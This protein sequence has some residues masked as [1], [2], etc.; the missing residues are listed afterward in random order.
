MTHF[1]DSSKVVNGGSVK[2]TDSGAT[3]LLSGPTEESVRIEILAREQHGSR[4]V[5]APG[6]VGARWF[7]TITKP[8]T[9]RPPEGVSETEG[10]APRCKIER[11]GLQVVVRG[12]TEEAVHEAIEN[13]LIGGAK[14]LAPPE[15]ARGEW[16]AVL[17][18]PR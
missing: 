11:L 17:Y 7:A 15:L 10:A 6:R 8:G 9:P 12:P 1:S 4:L 2:V 16:S 14:V 3:L 18:A 5:G 13:L